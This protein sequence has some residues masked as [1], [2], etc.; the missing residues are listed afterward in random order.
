MRMPGASGRF[1]PSD[2]TLVVPP[3]PYPRVWR[4]TVDDDFRRCQLHRDRAIP[5]VMPE[6]T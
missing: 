5:L 1:E 2:A 3:D 4:I 6:R